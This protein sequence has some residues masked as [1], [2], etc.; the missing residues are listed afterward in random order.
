M[1][2]YG[3]GA[4]IVL[5]SASI[6][7]FRSRPTTDH[8]HA[9]ALL[10]EEQ[11]GTSID[12]LLAKRDL[13]L[14]VRAFF[15]PGVTN[16]SSSAVRNISEQATLL[17]DH[18]LAPRLLDN[19]GL[20][21]PPQTRIATVLRDIALRV[22]SPGNFDAS[23]FGPPVAH[24]HSEVG[25]HGINNLFDGYDFGSFDTS[26]S[27]TALRELASPAD[28]GFGSAGEMALSLEWEQLFSNF[29]YVLFSLSFPLGGVS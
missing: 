3:I 2:S 5:F 19:N 25:D 24:E 15:D 17:I 16:P 18:I 27:R 13:I 23:I 20:T 21:I 14:G 26:V 11:A 29:P 4:V 6:P 22:K 28:L 8:P 9:A 12:N 7:P 10:R 1:W